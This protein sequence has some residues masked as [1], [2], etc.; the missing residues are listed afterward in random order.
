MIQLTVDLQMQW[1]A[2]VGALGRHHNG[3]RFAT[4]LPLH[5]GRRNRVDG[6]SCVSLLTSA[7]G[8]AVRR[9]GS[10]D[11]IGPGNR[12]PLVAV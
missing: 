10:S 11:G 6:S 9:L 8:D 12:S 3:Q 7:K 4:Q 2:A 5:E 1:L